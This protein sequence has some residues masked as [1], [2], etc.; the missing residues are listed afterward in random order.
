MSRRMLVAV[1]AALCVSA[2]VADDLKDVVATTQNNAGGVITFTTRDTATCKGK[3]LEAYTVA[4]DNTV[5]TGCW[6]VV[7]EYF[8]VTWGGEANGAVRAYNMGTLH[9]S[10]W[11]I[12]NVNKPKGTPL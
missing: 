1:A 10:D 5:G 9:F 7:D 8:V 11:F 12:A 6:R 3:G 2:A 4:A